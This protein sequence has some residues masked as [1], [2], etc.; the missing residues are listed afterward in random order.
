ME[1]N[2]MDFEQMMGE[3]A[4]MKTD[5][6]NRQANRFGSRSSTPRD[7]D[8]QE[9]RRTRLTRAKTETRA[10]TLLSV[11]TT[12]LDQTVSP[13]TSVLSPVSPII[14]RSATAGANLRDPDSRLNHR[15]HRPTQDRSGTTAESDRNEQPVP[16]ASPAPRMRID[17]SIPEQST[18]SKTDAVESTT[19]TSG[20]VESSGPLP[21]GL[22][23]RESKRAMPVPLPP[24]SAQRSRSISHGSSRLPETLVDENGERVS[25]GLDSAPA[26]PQETSTA[27]FDGP[28]PPRKFLRPYP[29]SPSLSTVASNG[30]MMPSSPRVP[31]RSNSRSYAKSPRP[32]PGSPSFPDP[33]IAQGPSSPFDQQQQHPHQ[34]QQYQQ[35][36]HQQYQYHHQQA[37]QSP[38]VP[39]RSRSASRSLS[40]SN[41]LNKSETK[42]DEYPFTATP[43]IAEDRETPLSPQEPPVQ[44]IVPAQPQQQQEQP[45]QQQEQP[46]QQHEQPQQPQE[47]EQEPLQP[48]QPQQQQQEELVEAQP[49][50]QP[51]LDLPPVESLQQQ[52]DNENKQQHIVVASEDALQ[53]GVA[54]STDAGGY[55]QKKSSNNSLGQ[56]N[57][58]NDAQHSLAP[59][60]LPAHP[61]PSRQASAQGDS[62]S[63]DGRPT[64]RKQQSADPAA[65]YRQH[66]QEAPM[67]DRLPNAS[68]NGRSR[69]PSGAG[70]AQNESE[71]GRKE[72][73]SKGGMFAW[74][75]SR[76]KSRDASHAKHTL[77][78][79]HPVP[80]STYPEYNPALIPSRSASQRSKSLPRK[81]S[82][83]NFQ[84][85][86][87]GWPPVPQAGL[88]GDSAASLHQR[89]KSTSKF[90][91]N[92]P[93]FANSTAGPID[94]S[95]A[96]PSLSLNISTNKNTMHHENMI[97]GMGMGSTPMTP[98]VLLTPQP[99]FPT[100]QSPLAAGG[101]RGMAL[102]MMK[103]DNS[104]SSSEQ[105]MQQRHAQLQQAQM[106]H[107]QQQ[108]QRLAASV[109][110]VN[111]SPPDSPASGNQSSNA[112]QS[113][114]SPTGATAGANSGAANQATQRLVATRIYIQTEIDFKSVNLAPNSTALDALHMLQERGCFGQPGDGRY[115][116]RW[117]IFE[118]SKEFLIERPLRDFEVILDVMKTW[119]AD[120]DNKMICKSYPVR[121]ELTAQEVVRLV[122]PAGQES[123]VR[124]HGWVH[125]EMKKS[126]WVKRYLHITDT[127]VYHSKDAKFNGESMLCLLRNFDVYAV[128]V[129]RKKAPT[130]FG[131]ALKS[132]D[133]IH[134]FETPEDD[135][136]HY[137]CTDSGESLREWLAGL[138]AAKGMFMYHANPEM[139]RE[140]QKHAAQLLSSSSAS[141]DGL[142][143]GNLTEE[144]VSIAEAK[145]AGWGMLNSS[146]RRTGE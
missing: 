108:Q 99:S 30:Q 124:P 4:A 130:K 15:H 142:A 50:P 35:H 136:I 103:D 28:V 110:G 10:D 101:M 53:R 2:D 71:R 109:A 126:K 65:M 135:Y 38:V 8:Q 42:H 137:I 82:N 97:R 93:P 133:K 128:Q 96:P 143:R 34:Q 14:K 138:R 57:E 43:S 40:R 36:Q 106:L 31:A 121:N 39:P 37:P 102:A 139:I 119:E 70:E 107:L 22:V 20:N 59:S 116:D 3:L 5:L 81:A 113:P 58:D 51:Q 64:L 29:S 52:L 120:K 91:R 104:P 78:T 9:P 32:V 94:T 129:P 45:Q 134:L 27:V 131:F 21:G 95:G 144:Q 33:P 23:R 16:P 67:R 105:Q 25:N 89:S 55:I 48:L 69:E 11:E 75:R 44:Q 80:E 54:N 46:Q 112:Q 61:I 17:A 60:L 146:M 68:E 62:N 7:A 24:K 141:Q 66:Q 73:S 83:Q 79:S 88:N 85:D 49:Q 132:S 76:S 111:G 86:S 74:V 12:A 118:Y 115:H 63:H 77:D 117:T 87:G 140:G 114:M 145:L 6:A 98:A 41:T 26:T 19:N 122:G 84:A 90:N 123:F 18:S 127:A 100:T 92:P 1:Q 47:Q 125:L 56:G 72:G 13:N